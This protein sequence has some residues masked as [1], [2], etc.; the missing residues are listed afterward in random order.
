[1]CS[2]RNIAPR[3]V[4]G[5]ETQ[6]CAT[7]VSNGFLVSADPLVPPVEQKGTLTARGLDTPVTRPGCLQ[8]SQPPRGTQNA[9]L[10]RE[11]E[12]SIKRRS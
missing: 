10:L 2:R 11:Q 12:C 7:D 4:R 8:L 6:P 3:T 1:M 5:E 9:D